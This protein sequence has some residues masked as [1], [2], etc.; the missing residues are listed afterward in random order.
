MQPLYA[1]RTAHEL[2]ATVMGQPNASSYDLVR[3][4]WQPIGGPD[5]E[6]W[7]RKAL[8]DGII[9]Q[10]TSVPTTV[11]APQLPPLAPIEQPEGMSLVLRPDPCIW[12]GSVGQ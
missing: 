4:T 12:D 11:A 10:T 6:T 7:W 2:L 3:E 1:S 5:F 9:A 8:H